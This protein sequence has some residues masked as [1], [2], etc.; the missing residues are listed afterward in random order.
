MLT[1]LVLSVVEPTWP[2]VIPTYEAFVD[3]LERAVDE[4]PPF[5]TF[6][7]RR[8]AWVLDSLVAT[9][10]DD[11]IDSV[12]SAWVLRSKLAAFETV[13]ELK[14][15]YVKEVTEKALAE[16]N[17]RATVERWL[18]EHKE[19]CDDAMDEAREAREDD[20]ADELGEKWQTRSSRRLMA[21][22]CHKLRELEW[23]QWDVML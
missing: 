21:A 15:A 20:E 17:M 4:W 11:P 16:A 1:L 3:E 8:N 5:G 2:P 13:A 7:Q 12:R 14:R 23:G 19:G 22:Y 9:V 10:S 6:V 18:S